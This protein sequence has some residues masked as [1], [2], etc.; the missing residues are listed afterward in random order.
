MEWLILIV[1]VIFVFIFLTKRKLGEVDDFPYE[2]NSTLFS[3]A[4]RSFYGVLSEATKDKAIVFGKVRVADILKTKKGIN[5]SS[6]QSA[7]NRISSKHFDFVLC[8]PE[9]IEILAAIELDDSSHNSKKRMERDKFL[10]KACQAANLELHHFK[11]KRSYSITEVRDH[12][13]PKKNKAVIN[14]ISN[15]SERIEPRFN[16]SEDQGKLSCP[17]CSSELIRKV[18]KKGKHKGSYFL[19]CSAFPKCRYIEKQNA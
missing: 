1:L 3:E 9:S 15:E 7:F 2:K 14:V 19:A 5:H 18:A 16:E 13:F 6:R 4:E 10:N 17:K 11:A 12:L 8:H